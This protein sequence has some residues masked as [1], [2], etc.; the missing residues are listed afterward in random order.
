[1]RKKILFLSIMILNLSANCQIFKDK[2]VKDATKVAEIWMKNINSSEY[3]IAYNQY[4]D[5]V[6]ENSDSTHWSKAI[7]QLMDEFGEIVS[8]ENIS[9]EFKSN[10]EGIGDGFFV[11]IEYKSIY[12]NIDECTEYLILGQDDSMKWKILR[13]DYSYINKDQDL[14]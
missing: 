11:F 7:N 13:Y 10:I 1:M 14:D 6:K 12:K 3:A 2:Y 9:T 5:Q 8:R 4:S